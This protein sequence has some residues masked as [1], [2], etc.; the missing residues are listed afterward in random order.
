[1]NRKLVASFALLGVVALAA[2]VLANARH[3]GGCRH[4]EGFLPMRELHQKLHLSA[5]QDK[6]WQALEK[7]SMAQ[8]KSAFAQHKEMRAQFLQELDKKD[9]DL[10]AL[11][12]RMDQASD[13]RIKAMRQLRGEWLKLYASLSAEQKG[14]VRDVLKAKLAHR[15]PFKHRGEGREPS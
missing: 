12:A 7:Q 1:M 9:P 14:I 2:P 10:A 8:R 15:G 5:E 4:G 11:S 13:E 6:T 3:E